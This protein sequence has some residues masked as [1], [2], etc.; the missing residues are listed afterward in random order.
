ME[1]ISMGNY[2]MEEKASGEVDTISNL[3][4]DAKNRWLTQLIVWLIIVTLVRSSPY[5]FT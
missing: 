1:E 3:S 2:H 4:Q 5:S